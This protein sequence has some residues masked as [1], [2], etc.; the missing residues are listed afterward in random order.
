V[1]AGL[2]G[3][4]ITLTARVSPNGRY[5]AFMSERMLHAMAEVAAQDERLDELLAEV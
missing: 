5:L 3:G 4:P 2:F 1:S